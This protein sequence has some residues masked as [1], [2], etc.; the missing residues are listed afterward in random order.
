[1]RL[2]LCCCVLILL[3]GCAPKRAVVSAPRAA[4]LPQPP[5]L[6]PSTETALQAPGPPPTGGVTNYVQLRAGWRLRVTTSLVP[7]GGYRICGDP[8]QSSPT[9]IAV[10][11]EG[12]KG[13]E[14][15]IYRI[16]ER[17][18]GGISIEFERAE[19]VRDNGRVPSVAPRADLFRLPPEARFARLLYPWCGSAIDVG[20]WLIAAEDGVALDA[21][22]PH[23]QAGHGCPPVSTGQLCTWIPQ[24]TAV[25]P[26]RRDDSGT[27]VPVQ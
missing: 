11:A 16:V 19:E 20:V 5:A 23:V 12:F 25:V 8:R 2:G 6:A 24:G 10:S 4:D 15:A 7:P 13:Y 1:M 18:G 17:P 3:A 26:E 14:T 21:M 22:A 9:T 27:W